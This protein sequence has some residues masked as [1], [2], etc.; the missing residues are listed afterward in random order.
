MS[1]EHSK[2]AAKFTQNVEKTTWHDATFWSV[3]PKREIRWRRS[4]PEEDLRE[5]YVPKPMHTI[6]HLS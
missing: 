3:L 2:R 4:F 5:H 1:T 6:T